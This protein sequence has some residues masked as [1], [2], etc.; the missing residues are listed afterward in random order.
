M[1]TRFV[2]RCSGVRPL[3]APLALLAIFVFAFAATPQTTFGQATGIDNP[4]TFQLEGNATTEGS[5]CFGLTAAGAVTATPAPGCPA[6]TSVVTFGASSDDWE[7]ALGFKAGSPSHALKTA[8]V[9]AATTPSEPFN[10]SSDTTFFG[11]GAKDTSGIS[12]GPWEWQD[13]SVNAKDDIEHA[14]AAA[15]TLPFHYDTGTKSFQVCGGAGQPGCD[16]G[17]YFG[18]D[19]FDNSG[20]A[21]AGFWF[22]QDNAVALVNN[23]KGGGFLFSGH[24][25]NND[26]LIVSDFS[27]GG[28]VGTIQAFKWSCSGSGAACDSG[29]SLANV[30]ALITNPTCN[31]AADPAT[32][33]RIIC[34]E[35]NG[36]DGLAA[37]WGF[38]NKS[39]QSTYAHGEFLEGGVDLQALFGS[40]I[41]C[42]SRFMA[43]TRSSNSP[44]ASLEDLTPPI[45]FSLCG[46]GITKV[47][48]TGGVSPNA[49]SGGQP[50]EYGAHGQITNIGVG[51]VYNIAIYDIPNGLNLED[52]SNNPLNF[53]QIPGQATGVTGVSAMTV[54]SLAPGACLNWPANTPCSGGAVSDFLFQSSTDQPTN[55][56]IAN[57]FSAQS[58]GELVS[59]TSDSDPASPGFQPATCPFVS[60]PGSLEAHKSC[61]SDTPATC[62]VPT[63][64]GVIV[65]VNF[66]GSVC[67]TSTNSDATFTSV[68]I[69]DVNAGSVTGSEAINITW[70]GTTGT[71]KP[72]ECAQ[73]TG[74]YEPTTAPATGDNY[75]DHL[76]ATATCSLCTDSHSK[77]A[78]STDATCPVCP[79]AGLNAC[80]P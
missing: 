19:R 15:Y 50:F 42:I 41:P 79:A 48:P 45:N 39:G 47:C 40:N 76:H 4:N 37:P 16:T 54:A 52:A 62:L 20:D 24:H 12:S 13:T 65:K 75:V 64:S 10:S 23:K 73:V 33:A 66:I 78:D 49:T 68:S 59:A 21:T 70:P 30:T 53:V 31:P 44:T 27:T 63:N 71:L 34:A 9:G 5:I 7:N 74:S 55:Q 43:E 80:T 60:I 77:S 58:G 25:T 35:V 46:V 61:A 36:S 56:A 11:G 6:G 29:G 17:I 69:S 32:G 1:G 14:F 57:A 28:A 22:F 72:S 67:N 18:M 38:T 26:L 8:F 51:T 3:V 2:A